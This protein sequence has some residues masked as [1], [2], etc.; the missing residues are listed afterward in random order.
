[1]II[2]DSVQNT[3]MF[4]LATKCY[5]RF[6]RVSGRVIDPIYMTENQAYAEYIMWLASDSNDAELWRY[7]AQLKTLLTTSQ[8]QENIENYQASQVL[9]STAN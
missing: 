1:M 2:S 5:V 7:A 3:E 6:R 9:D 8:L 4:A